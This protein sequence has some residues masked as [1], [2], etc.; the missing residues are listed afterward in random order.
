MIFST[1]DA[2][3]DNPVTLLPGPGVANGQTL[4][5]W[6]ANRQGNDRS[7]IVARF[8]SSV[9]PVVLVTTQRDGR[10]PPRLSARARAADRPS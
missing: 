2:G 1:L 8:I 10:P 7:G 5:N 4:A 6:A 3:A 9:K